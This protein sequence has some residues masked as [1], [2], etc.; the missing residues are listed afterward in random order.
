MLIV[1]V[2]VKDVFCPLFSYMLK[3]LNSK[4]ARCLL[5]RERKTSAPMFFDLDFSRGLP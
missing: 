1:F 3:A 4:F 2:L 5:T